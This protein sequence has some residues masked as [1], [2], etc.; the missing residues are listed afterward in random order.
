[1]PALSQY[2]PWS[3]P[4]A[5]QFP[6]AS[7]IPLYSYPPSGYLPSA[8][9]YASSGWPLYMPPTYNNYS[10]PTGR[11]ITTSSCPVGLVTGLTLDEEFGPGTSQI[12]RC[13]IMT[14]GIKVVMDINSFESSPGRSYGIRNIPNMINDY[15]ITHG[16][17]DYKIVAINH[18]GGLT[19][20]LNRNAPNPHPDAALNVYQPLVEELI[21]KGVKFYG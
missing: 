20:L 6:G 16:T 19:Q 1:M 15:E 8:G 13:L 4:P 7:Q 11:I 2:L 21:A 9:P 5:S 3:W 17:K 14:Y 18:G 12:T 10:P